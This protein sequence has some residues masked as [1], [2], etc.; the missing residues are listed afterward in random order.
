MRYFLPTLLFLA[1]INFAYA[2]PRFSGC[3]HPNLQRANFFQSDLMSKYDIHYLKLDLNVEPDTLLIS[4]SCY[5]QMKA[6]QLLDTFAIEFKD[7]MIL[8]SVL[9]NGNKANFSRSN[10]HI[11]VPL[12]SPLTIGTNFTTQFF[13]SGIV[14]LGLAYGND[15]SSGL[16]Y[17]GTLSESFQAREWFPAKQLLN[18]K[19]DSTDIWLTTS[20]PY[21]AGSNG[22]LVNT[23]AKPGNKTQY[24]WSTKYPQ[25]YYMPCFA[26]GNFQDY[27]NYAKP[28]AM[29]GDSILIQNLIVDN[30]F[31][32]A[33]I[34]ANLD[35]TPI[36]IEKMSELFSLYP[37]A[38]EKYGH[39]QCNIGGGMEHQTMSTMQGFDLFLIGHELAH[40]WFGDNVTCAT[41]QDIWLNEG[42]A[43]YIESLMR[44]FYPSLFSESFA[45][46]LLTR[47]QNIMAYPGGSV[48]ISSPTFNENRIFSGR[49]SYDKGGAILHTLRFEMQSDSLFFKTLRTYQ[50]QFKDSFATTTDFKQIAEQVSGKNLTNFFNQWVYGHGYP[51]YDVNYYKWGND[52]LVINVNQTT[53]SPTVT[54]LFTGLMEYKI[55]STQGD[56]I[57]LLNNTSNN[58]TFRIA[59]AKVP[60][61]VEVDPNNWIINK[62]N[63]VLPV[64]SI[65]LQGKMDNAGAIIQWIAFGQSNVKNYELQRSSDGENFKTIST[66]LPKG[67]AA[68]QNQYQ[69]TDKQPLSRS[70]YRVKVI[71]IDGSFTYSEII[72]LMLDKSTFQAFYNNVLNAIVVKADAERNEKLLLQLFDMQGKKIKETTKEF[73]AGFNQMNI[74]LPSLGAGVYTAKIY[75]AN[76]AKTLRIQK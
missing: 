65:S 29:N 58:Q 34:K 4:G 44:E 16:I 39:M 42:F 7:N 17:C 14:F 72:V 61:S 38:N 33:S 20:N 57:L 56:T 71:N 18:Y 32:F 24:Q 27:R 6:S 69:Y 76:Q 37:F 64:R 46:Q 60:T 40:Q 25:N 22:L 54:P 41:W 35:K 21:I 11:Y 1:L 70:Y 62:V 23:I 50:Q 26:A 43:T 52:T 2:Q 3:K 68:S 31:Y 15:A 10:D 30:P 5:Y 53:S 48:Y 45:Q 13:Y 9:I 59:Y 73:S 28:A 12:T 74:S 67:N 49:L 36:F 19:I 47:H 8:D 51:T 75:F 63:S 55:S 66:M